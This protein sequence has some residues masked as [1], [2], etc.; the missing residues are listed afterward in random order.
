MRFPGIREVTVRRWRF[1]GRTRS[2]GR[3]VGAASADQRQVDLV[4]DLGEDVVGDGGVPAGD[5]LV[6]E[7]HDGDTYPDMPWEPK[8]AFTMLADYYSN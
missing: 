5:E 4:D 6:A 3:L 7:Q 2:E 1:A 8:A